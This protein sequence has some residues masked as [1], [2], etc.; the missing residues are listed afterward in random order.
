[1][2]GEDGQEREVQADFGRI[3][4]DDLA[5]GRILGELGVVPRRPVLPPIIDEVLNDS[6][7]ERA[8]LR[9]GDRILAVD[10]VSIRDW[11]SWVEIVRGSPGRRLDVEV[12]R[13]DGSVT[14]LTVVP[15]QQQAG[16]R[17][18]GRIGATVDPAAAIDHGLLAVERY[19]VFGA[20]GQS[21][22]RTWEMSL[23]TLRLL[24]RMVVGEAS[25]KNLSGPISIAQY[26]GESAG[27]GLVAFLGF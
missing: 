10:G 21:V 12:A 18:I 11:G 5:G 2:A 4:V 16:D 9:S 13:A 23:L 27:I 14:S 1:V 25:V 24:A 17:V 20:L 8:G 6:P 26:A 15:E 19:G 3:S 22:E 7:A